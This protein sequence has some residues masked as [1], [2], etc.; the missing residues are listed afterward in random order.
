MPSILT[1]QST[2]HIWSDSNSWTNNVPGTNTNAYL[3]SNCTINE[4]NAVALNVYI[5]PSSVGYLNLVSGSLK[6]GENLRVGAGNYGEMHLTG[7]ALTVGNRLSVGDP[8]GAG[9]IFEV[10]SGCV[11]PV[12]DLNLNSNAHLMIDVDPNGHGILSLGSEALLYQGTINLKFLGGLMPE[13]NQ[14]WTI[15]Q[16]DPNSFVVQNGG[17]LIWGTWTSTDSKGYDPNCTRLQG[18]AILSNLTSTQMHQQGLKRFD[19]IRDYDPNTSCQQLTIKAVP[20]H[21]G[22]ANGDGYVDGVDFLIWQSHYPTPSGA[23]WDM[24]DFNHDGKVDGDDFL[25]WQSNQGVWHG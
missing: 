6:V 9:G 19:A 17:E 4:A 7:G 15:I 12:F 16:P 8:G 21:P 23:T 10:G 24:G 1:T 20:L 22:D 5:G 14:T 13:P 18:V 25:I 3:E 11:A 2:L